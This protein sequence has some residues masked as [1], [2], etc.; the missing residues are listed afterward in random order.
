MVKNKDGKE[1]RDILNRELTLGDLVLI[2]G[3]QS[4][5]FKHGII[6]VKSIRYSN[7]GHIA[8]DATSIYLVENPSNEE[9]EIRN[10]ILKWC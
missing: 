9:I 1:V 3:K 10:Q 7:G 5:M 8:L 4:G 6:T 2:K